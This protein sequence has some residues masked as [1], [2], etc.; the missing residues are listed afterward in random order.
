MSRAELARND[1]SRSPQFGRER[2]LVRLPAGRAAQ[3]RHCILCLDVHAPNK[4]VGHVLLA[5]LVGPLA[6]RRLGWAAYQARPRARSS[7][8]ARPP[9][10]R[11][12][13]GRGCSASYGRL[14]LRRAQKGN[15]L[16]TTHPRAWL[17][18]P[19]PREIALA[20]ARGRE[21]PPGGAAATSARLWPRI[22]PCR[23]SLVAAAC[24]I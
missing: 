1:G 24:L 3:P 11:P 23:V 14:R 17:A 4:H 5:S 7:R 6:A 12:S 18:A 13:R 21:R 10:A 16:A 8:P 9:T 20:R 22:A 2:A 15:L 19:R